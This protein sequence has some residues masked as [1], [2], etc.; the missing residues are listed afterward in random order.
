MRKTNKS[1]F[2][3]ELEKYVYSSTE[4]SYSDTSSVFIDLMTTIHMHS[5]SKSVTFDDLATNIESSVLSNFKEGGVLVVVPDRY[6]IL[7]SIKGE[8]KAVS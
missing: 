7:N 6:D 4:I 5:T 8:K 3:K 2:V 1:D